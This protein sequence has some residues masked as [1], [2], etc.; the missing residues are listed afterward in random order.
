MADEYD[1]AEN[2]AVASKMAASAT[3]TTDAI[4]STSTTT[5][6]MGPCY[7]SANDGSTKLAGGD[8]D[9]AAAAKYDAPADDDDAS[10]DETKCMERTNGINGTCATYCYHYY[11]RSENECRGVYASIKN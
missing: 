7:G 10:T 4:S 3:T 2:T 5:R 6:T 11:D 1:A 8:D 9:D